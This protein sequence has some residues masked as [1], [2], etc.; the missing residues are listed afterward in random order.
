MGWEGVPTY[1]G[2]F[3]RGASE[4]LCF[5]KQIK[6]ALKVRH[7][8]RQPPQLVFRIR[9]I[10]SSCLAVGTQ[11]QKYGINIFLYDYL[12]LLIC[13]KRNRISEEDYA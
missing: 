3:S 2:S 5:W 4:E 13:S 1:T 6:G 11:I 7:S 9:S 10:L 12:G 8:I